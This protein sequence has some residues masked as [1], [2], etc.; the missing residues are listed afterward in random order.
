MGITHMATSMQAAHPP[1]ACWPTE[2]LAIFSI[3][4]SGARPN[5]I[6]SIRSG[7]VPSNPQHLGKT[8]ALS[9]WA[10]PPSEQ[11][12]GNILGIVRKRS[13]AFLILLKFSEEKEVS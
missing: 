1:R 3:L 2:R 12:Q 6:P 10:A 7:S 8:T 4:A 9:A 11:G 5:W 13:P